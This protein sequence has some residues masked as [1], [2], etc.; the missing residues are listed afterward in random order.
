[1]Q[2]WIVCMHRLL[3]LSGLRCIRPHVD[4]RSLATAPATLHRVCHRSRARVQG[5]LSRRRAPDHSE[6]V[7]PTP[8]R[9]LPHEA[10]SC[11]P[12]SFNHVAEWPGTV[13]CSS[14]CASVE[15]CCPLAELQTSSRSWRGSH[16]TAAVCTRSAAGSMRR[17]LR[18]SSGRPLG[19]V[20][21][22]GC[23]LGHVAAAGAVVAAT[24]VVRS[25]AGESRSIARMQAADSARDCRYSAAPSGVV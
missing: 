8:R 11:V 3:A 25:A 7:S 1:M 12:A 17:E 21:R 24:A 19:G 10:S 16:G 9:R 13:L 6:C 2:Q 20:W 4:I 15:Q 18:C 22:G 5:V 23:R 14:T